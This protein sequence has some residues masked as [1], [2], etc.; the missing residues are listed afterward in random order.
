[1]KKIIAFLVAA[2][3][4]YAAAALVAPR[5]YKIVTSGKAYREG[6]EMLKGG[7]FERGLERVRF[8]LFVLHDEPAL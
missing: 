4:V 1:M 8:S 7:D 5:Y 2:I 6:L 3:L